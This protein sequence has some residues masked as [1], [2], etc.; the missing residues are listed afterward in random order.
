MANYDETKVMA[1]IKELIK[2][3]EDIK[4]IAREFKSEVEYAKQ[5]ENK[6]MYFL[7]VLQQKKYPVFDIFEEHIKDL[8][9]ARFSTNLDDKFKEIYVEQKKRMKDLGLID[10]RELA[11]T[12]RDHPVCKLGRHEEPSFTSDGSYMPILN[13]PPK[14]PEKPSGVPCLDF[15]KMN[16]NLMKQEKQKQ[17]AK[18]KAQMKPKMINSDPNR[19]GKSQG[20][21]FRN[22]NPMLEEINHNKY[23]D[24]YDEYGEG[25]S[26]PCS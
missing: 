17:I 14:K 11:N 1:E 12:V 16:D 3:N 22:V 6:L 26:S 7:F 13:S 25:E 18:Q 10:D 5:R 24:N 23:Q 19:H 9:T 2:E 15:G 20:G 8:P 4:C 21:S